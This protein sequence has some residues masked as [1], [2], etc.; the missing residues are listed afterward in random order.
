M[1][2]EIYKSIN[3]Y[4]RYDTYMILYL[5]S[6]TFSQHFHIYMNTCLFMILLYELA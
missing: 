3:L 6:D 5:I 1:S 4:I 2:C